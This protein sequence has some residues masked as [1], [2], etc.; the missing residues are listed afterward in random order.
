MNPVGILVILIVSALAPPPETRW[1]QPPAVPELVKGI[2]V[3]RKL[4]GGAVHQFLLPLKAGEFARIR[5]EQRGI[6]VVLRLLDERGTVL[7]ET[8][9]P[10][11]GYGPEEVVWAAK[12]ASAFKIE[13]RALDE[14][15]AEGIYLAQRIE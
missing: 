12:Q 3:E 15:A 5:V 13:V 6:D 14:K 1:Q 7:A 9:R 10:N 8:D 11:G 4:A 2:P